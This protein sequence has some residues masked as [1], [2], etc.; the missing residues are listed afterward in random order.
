MNFGAD[1]LVSNTRRRRVNSGVLDKVR[2]QTKYWLTLQWCPTR[3]AFISM[4]GDGYWPTVQTANGHII[5][6]SYFPDGMA[7]IRKERIALFRNTSGTESE[8]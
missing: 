1:M 2:H 4:I 5:F 8:S 7:C 3:I 6:T